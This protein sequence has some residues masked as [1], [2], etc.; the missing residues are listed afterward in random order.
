MATI[1]A[2]P[3]VVGGSLR[4]WAGG[5]PVSRAADWSPSVDPQVVPERRDEDAPI[6]WRVLL[7]VVALFAFT[8]AFAGAVADLAASAAGTSA[9]PAAPVTPES[10]A[11]P[12]WTVSSGD[13]LWS[14]A[15]ALQPQADPRETVLVLREL[16][17]LA[18]D[19]VLQVGEV[20]QLPA[21]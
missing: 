14:I 21:S 7:A 9:A 2:S 13:T 8:L 15:G 3:Q 11:Y 12:A 18:P 10:G 16:N 5:S 1:S 6:P 19:H 20:L 17:G 4:G